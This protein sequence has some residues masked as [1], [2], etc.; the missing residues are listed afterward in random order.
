MPS[1]FRNQKTKD[2]E[3]KLTSAV[4][5]ASIS[6]ADLEIEKKWLQLARVDGADFEFFYRKYYDTILIF[7]SGE[8]KDS[9]VAQ[10]LTNEVFSLALDKLDKFQWQ[11]YSFGA[12]LFQIAR[13]LRSEENRKQSLNL[14]VPW[15]SEHEDVED[16]NA[17]AELKDDTDVLRYCIENLDPVRRQ[18]FQAR[19]W[20]R[21]KVKEIA[22]VL[23]LNVSQV[24]NHLV[25]GRVHLR[26]CLMKN[27]L[28]RGL[29]A[30]KMKMIDGS[31][32]EDE[33]WGLV[34]DKDGGSSE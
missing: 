2:T 25:R 28:E 1:W 7:I 8:I 19:Y 33:G 13:N 21:M 14:E 6:P 9:H 27:G 24:K 12:W 3:V 10:E 30:E 23:D 5:L 32:I 34:E 20:S 16:P 15:E 11:G 29:S 18:V 22:I 31:A 26:R 4:E 17:D